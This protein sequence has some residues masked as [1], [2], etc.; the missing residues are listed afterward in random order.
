MGSIDVEETRP[1]ETALS[2]CKQKQI[3]R[4]F[5]VR[6]NDNGFPV[7]EWCHPE[8]SEGSVVGGRRAIA[9]LCTSRTPRIPRYARNDTIIQVKS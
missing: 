8:R 2:T 4:L 7:S 6:G 9:F 1:G 5:P 3:P